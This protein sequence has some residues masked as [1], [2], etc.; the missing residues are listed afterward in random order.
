MS[1]SIARAPYLAACLSTLVVLAP[2]VAHAQG[3]GKQA[4]AQALFEDA[5]KL[6]TKGDFAAACPK[7]NDSQ[8]LDP[9]P[10]TQFNLANCYEKVGQTASAWATFKSA[11]ASYRAHSRGDWETKA[12]D[13]A[14]ALEPKLSK[15]TVV[16]PPE[17]S[18]PGLEVKRD[19]Q[20]LSASELGAPIPVDPGDH[21]IEAA[22]PG[23][24]PW[25]TTAK[26][27]PTPGEQKVAVGPLEAEPK[28]AVVA[29]TPPPATTTTTKPPPAT[30]TTTDTPPPNKGNGQKTAAY[31]ALGVGG[32]GLVVGSVTGVMAMSKNKT[33]TDACPNDGACR[34]QDAVDANSSAKSL[35]TVST[36]GFIVG[37]VGLAA[38]I[39]LLATAPSSAPKTGSLHIVPTAGPGGG[40]LAAF[41]TF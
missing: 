16:V 9:A 38:G 15:L 36:I 12:R 34:S 18:V 29:T 20:A 7:F 22:A 4:A 39:V 28:A 10:G 13:R 33:A 11:A 2:A 21:T 31:V 40:G 17:S 25:K 32:V 3:A 41:G 6:M 8:N 1:R 14:S 37:G 35:A 27:A 5:K 24:K 30:T 19:G 23:K 26:V